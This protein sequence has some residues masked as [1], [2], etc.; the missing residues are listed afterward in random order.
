MNSYPNIEKSAFR[1]GEYVGYARGVWR[2]TG[3]HGDWRAIP[4]GGGDGRAPIMAS[5]LAE[6]SAELANANRRTK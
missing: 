5:T 4:N 3:R 6:I 1:R 2:I